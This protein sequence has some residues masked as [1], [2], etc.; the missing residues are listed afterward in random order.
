ME[1]A[2]FLEKFNELDD[3]EISDT[4][5]LSAIKEAKGLEA[6]LNSFDIDSLTELEALELKLLADEW[7]SK[8]NAECP[9]IGQEIAVTGEVTA[10]SYDQF[11]NSVSIETPRY[12]N[13]TVISQGYHVLLVTDDDDSRRYVAGHYFLAETMEARND[14]PVLTDSINRF[15]SFAPVGS[16]D[17][18]ADVPEN[19]HAGILHKYIADIVES[20][21]YEIGRADSEA[22]ALCRLRSIVM[23]DVVNIPEDTINDLLNYTYDCLGLDETV[24]YIATLRGVVY[25]GKIGADGGLA[26]ELF[27]NNAPQV[28]VSPIELR[29]AQY[30][31]K[32]QGNYEIDQSEQ[33]MIKLKVIDRSSESLDRTIFAPVRNIKSL[34]SLRTITDNYEEKWYRA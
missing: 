21:N 10:A 16:V 15:Y 17:I 11:T 31:R 7:V 4:Y 5:T 6:F 3:V 2:E 12:I 30:P 14:G 32:V 1:N 24:P 9:Y 19:R 20:V 26:F 18:V 23:D 27:D 29:I 22:D 25:Q 8:M 34:R 28:I 33:F 13:H